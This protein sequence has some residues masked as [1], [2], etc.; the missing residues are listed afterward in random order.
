MNIA[1]MCKVWVVITSVV[2]SHGLW[3]YESCQLVT[4]MNDE[5]QVRV[6]SLNNFR[7]L[8]EEILKVKEL[9]Q[10]LN[11]T[12]SGREI[13]LLAQRFDEELGV[14]VRDRNVS[15][16]VAGVSLG[17]LILSSIFIKKLAQSSQGLGFKKRLMAQLRPSGERAVVRTLLNTAVFVG[18]VSLLWNVY[19]I[20]QNQN[21]VDKLRELIEKLDQLWDL[22][23][24]IQ[25]QEEHLEELEINREFLIDDLRNQG[26]LCS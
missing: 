19:Q 5:I 21:D 13:L 25:E 4:M 26:I 3:A 14:E 9:R 22:S 7:L 16:G 23:Q 10:Q 20:H 17:S 2:L 24:K 15:V 11:T 6:Q 18:V 1:K 12:E 8:Q